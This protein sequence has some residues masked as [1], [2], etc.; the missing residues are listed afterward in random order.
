MVR[1]FRFLQKN[2]S[3]KSPCF[4]LLAETRGFLREGFSRAGPAGALPFA[5]GSFQRPVKPLRDL[6]W[7]LV[8]RESAIAGH[9]EKVTKILLNFQ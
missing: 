9:E 1:S 4:N 3:G 6:P 8:Y 2:K 5:S 7:A